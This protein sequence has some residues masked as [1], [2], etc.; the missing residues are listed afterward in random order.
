M[1]VC[2]CSLN[3]IIAAD[4]TKNGRKSPLRNFPFRPITQPPL[5]PHRLSS[6]DQ[7]HQ[8]QND[9]LKLKSKYSYDSTGPNDERYYGKCFLAALLGLTF[10]QWLSKFFAVSQRSNNHNS[11]NNNTRKSKFAGYYSRDSI[12]ELEQR[13]ETFDRRRLS[14]SPGPELRVASPS[15]RQILKKKF[16]DKASQLSSDLRFFKVIFI[17]YHYK[18][19]VLKRITLK[20]RRKITATFTEHLIEM[21]QKRK[22][23]TSYPYS[24]LKFPSKTWCEKL[25]CMLKNI[26]IS[27]TTEIM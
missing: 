21:D 17:L 3:N 4:Q 9:H 22:K 12:D 10:L 23:S 13:D 18:S 5:F 1:F 20:C 15:K 24:L 25:S 26:L 27:A 19:Q 14:H 6:K 8:R 16:Q 11:S 2:F 7:Q